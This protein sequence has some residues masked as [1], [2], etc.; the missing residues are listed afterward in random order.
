MK[1]VVLSIMIVSMSLSANM[2]YVGDDRARDYYENPRIL[3]TLVKQ[4]VDKPLIVGY[5]KVGMN[6][7]LK[8]SS[9]K[10]CCA[11]LSLAGGSCM[12]LEN[13]LKVK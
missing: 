13:G 11:N 8:L 5:Y 10:R 3:K 7:K 9:S 2:K 6:G 4:G 1:K 12:K